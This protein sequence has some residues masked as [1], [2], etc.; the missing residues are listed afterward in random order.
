M[1][2]LCQKLDKLWQEN[3]FTP[4]LYTWID[5][6]QQDAAEY[7][8]KLV[9]DR[10]TLY[11]IRWYFPKLLPLPYL[12]EYNYNSILPRCLR[13]KMCV[14]IFVRFRRSAHTSIC[15]SWCEVYYFVYALHGSERMSCFALH[16][17]SAVLA[18][19]MCRILSNLLSL[20]ISDSL[21]IETMSQASSDEIGCDPR[22]IQES[23]SISELYSYLVEYEKAQVQLV[24]YHLCLTFPPD[25]KSVV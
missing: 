13:M 11:Q 22:S 12:G 19:P 18:I 15:L 21:D 17:I 10:F 14:L 9:Y 23:N 8:G 25:R 2:L 24:C 3:E 7:L 5:F 6:L 20:G 1:T 4:I 16:P